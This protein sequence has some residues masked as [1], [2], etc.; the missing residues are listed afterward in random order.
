MNYDKILTALH[1]DGA[2]MAHLDHMQV[3]KTG[4]AT[5]KPAFQHR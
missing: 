4:D 2:A 3:Y 1:G 5:R